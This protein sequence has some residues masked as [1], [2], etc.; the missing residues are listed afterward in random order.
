MKLTCYVDH[1]GDLVTCDTNERIR[2][3]SVAEK[4]ESFAPSNYTGAFKADVSERTLKQRCP[5]LLW[6][7]AH[8]YPSCAQE[9]A[10]MTAKQKTGF[11]RYF[12]KRMEKQ[13]FA[14][15]Y[16]MART[17]ID[18]TDKLIRALNAVRERLDHLFA[19]LDKDR[20]SV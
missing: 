11:D 14:A 5:D 15:E 18:A 4:Q 12:E 20:A 2:R 3:A 19:A 10:P 17:E 8:P 6:Q 16:Q 1:Y 7:R 9:S 13:S